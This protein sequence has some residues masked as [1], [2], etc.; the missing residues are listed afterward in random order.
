MRLVCLCKR[1][2]LKR[3]DSFTK[4]MARK[5]YYDTGEEKIG[6][7]TGAELLELLRQGEISADT[8]AR[9]AESSTWRKLAN[10]DLKA[11]KE[12]EENKSIWRKILGQMDASSIAGVVF[13]IFF[14]I[15]MLILAGA[16]I[17]FLWPFLLVIF[18]F[19]ML[20]KILG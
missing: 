9:R 14:I 1:A 5:F 3:N 16:A 13:F 8:W 20:K 15:G 19:Y 11:E 10:T 17:S 12:K 6:P 4:L 2:H 18:A 7:V